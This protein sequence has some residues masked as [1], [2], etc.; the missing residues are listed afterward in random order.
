MHVQVKLVL[1]KLAIH[2]RKNTYTQT[3]IHAR[4]D[5]PLIRI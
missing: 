1:I 2:T 4:Q 5:F 3:R